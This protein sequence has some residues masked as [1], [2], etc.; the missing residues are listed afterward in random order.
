MSKHRKP[1]PRPAAAPSRAVNAPKQAIYQPPAIVAADFFKRTL[2]Q[3]GL[4]FALAF[5][6]YAN[7]LT[8][9][10]VLDDS[11]VINDNMFTQ[12]GTEGIAGILTKDTFFGYFKVEGKAELV[13]G[14]RYRPL[15]LML[16]AL[17]FQFFGEN[18]VVFH[19]LTVLLFAATCVVL[20]RTL[21]LLFVPR[22]GADYSLMLAWMAAVL[23]AVHPIHV[24]VVANIKGC[25]EIATLLGSL[26]ALYFTL[27]FFDTRK[28]AWALA[29]G[30]SFFLACL[31]KENAVTFLAVVP[32]ALWFFR[33]SQAAQQQAGPSVWKYALP[34][35]VAFVV[36]FVIRGNVLHWP[37]LVGG[38]VP[39]ELMNNP[40]LKIEGNEWVP[41]AFSEKLATVFFTLLKYVQLLFVPHPLTHD[42]YPK[43]I[44]MLR[45]GSPGALLGLA[46]YVFLAIYALSGLRRRDPV[47]FGILFYLLTISIVSNIVFPVGTLMGDR[48]V[49]MPSVGFCIAVAA[50]LIHY[51]GKNMQVA[52]GIFG[53]LALLYA[54]KTVTRNPAWAS[55]EKLFFTD[56]KVSLNSAKIHNACGGVLFDR[57]SKEKNEVERSEICTQAMMYL[58][59]A[60]QLYPNYKDAY[61]SRGGCNYYLK[62]YDA[63]VE[64][65]RRAWQLAEG[66]LKI[67]KALALVLRDGGKYH[68]EQ[69]GDLRQAMTYL[70]ESWQLNTEDGETARLLGVANG[71]QGKGADAVMWFEKSVALEPDNATYWFDLHLAYRAVGNAAKGEEALRKA[72]EIN[73]KIVEERGRK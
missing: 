11:I 18:S 40:F 37:K 30:I 53:I 50:L 65:Y 22:F 25:D 7:T 6:L 38:R 42:Y 58:N 70:S 48:F 64:D 33:P 73:P 72:L 57:A 55:N 1:A 28:V 54:F 41:W 19:L 69:R 63:A 21:L 60:I 71:V 49:F 2:L 16:F 29:A 62:N 39:M 56:V 5:L 43:Q 10:F 17:V 52:L 68:G 59:K 23:F 13:M 24:E 31:S 34:L 15:T 66:D 14:G 3:S 20:Y 32:L 8:H 44:E 61:M 12:K 4:I 36:F 27:K 45:F 9:G 46:L 51:F 47:R 35:L 67:K 26:G